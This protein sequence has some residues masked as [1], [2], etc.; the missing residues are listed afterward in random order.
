MKNWRKISTDGYTLEIPAEFTSAIG[1]DGH[2]LIHDP[3]ASVRMEFH[4]ADENGQAE[5]SGRENNSPPASVPISA[6]EARSQFLRWFRELPVM[7]IRAQPQLAPGEH[8]TMVT[9]RGVERPKNIAGWLWTILKVNTESRQEWRFWAV[10]AGERILLVTAHG[11]RRMMERFRATLDAITAGLCIR[12]AADGLKT[13][14]IEVVVNLAR[15]QVG[16]SSISAIDD[17]TLSVGGMRIKVSPL[18]QTYLDQPEALVDN[19]KRFFDDLLVESTDRESDDNGWTGV[20][21][22][23]FPILLPRSLVESMGPDVVREEWI[24]SLMICYQL[25]HRNSPITRGDC[26]QWGVDCE[27]LHAHAI[28][29]L[30]RRTR[31]LSMTGGP[32]ENYTLFGFPQEDSLNSSRMLLPL[33]YQHLRPHLGVTFYMAAPDRDVLLAFATED[34]STVAWLRRQVEM[35]FAQAAHPLSDKLF[36]ATPDGIVGDVQ[37]PAP[38]NPP[39]D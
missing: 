6:R 16:A 17:D 32:A 5:G 36:L 21:N 37:T 25:R 4:F 13:P 14:F 27:T 34:E 31:E 18:H 35:R 7:H 28:S 1:P 33:I 19:V 26:R 30:L 38:E 3:S 9:A 20:R 15:Q 23:V 2:L 10:Y 24:N 29:N 12:S 8:H 11:P 39:E 22:S